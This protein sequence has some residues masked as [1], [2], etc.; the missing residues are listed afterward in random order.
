MTIDE[1]IWGDYQGYH[2]A[3]APPPSSGGVFLLQ[4]LNLLNDFKLSQYDIRSW[5]KYQLLAET[6][7]LAY[8]DRA[9]FAGDPEFVN[10]P[11]KGLLNPDYINAR[12]QLI[13]IDKVNKTESRRS[14]IRKVLQ[15]I[16]KW[17]SRLTNRK[18]KRLTSR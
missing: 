13:D 4:M 18:V 15:T 2:I 16:N 12:R 5:Q 10:V 1:P 6:M 11:L 7:H 9:A 14:F 3:T 8:A 17:S